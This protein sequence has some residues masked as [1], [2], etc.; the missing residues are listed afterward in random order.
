MAFDKATCVQG[1]RTR[2]KVAVKW[3]CRCVSAHLIRVRCLSVAYDVFLRAWPGA[4]AIFEWFV[5]GPD[6]TGED[7]RQERRPRGGPSPLSV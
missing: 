1:T 7:G 2:G 5:A 3:K 6:S 4:N